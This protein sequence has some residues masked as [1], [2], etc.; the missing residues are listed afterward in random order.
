MIDLTDPAVATDLIT[1]ADASGAVDAAFDDDLSIFIDWTAGTDA[2]SGVASYTLKIFQQSSCGGSALSDITGLTGTSYN[3]TAPSEATYSFQLVTFDNAGN[4]SAASACS[5]DITIDQTN[6]VAATGLKTPVDVASG[7]DAD[8]DTTNTEIF[9]A[10][11]AATDAGSGLASYTLKRYDQASCGGTSSDT[12]GIGAGVSSQSFTGVEGTTYSFEVVAIDNAGNSAT[13]LCSSDVMIDLTSPVAA[14]GLKTPVDVASGADADYDTTNTEIFF[15]WTA[16]TDAESGLASYTLKRYDQASCGG[17]STDTA[18][19]GAG[20]T[21]QSFTGVEGTTYSFEVVAIDDAGNST[22]SACSSD[23]MIDLT[24]PAVATDLITPADAAGAVDA[25]FDDDLSIFIDWTAGTDAGSGVASYTLKIF[26]QSSCGGSALSDITGLTGIS[27]NYTAPSD[28]TYS[29]QL[30]TIDNAGR[31]SAASACST[32]ILIDSEN[33]TAATDLITPADAAGG[34]DAAFDDD[35]SFYISWTAGT[36]AGSGV[37]DYTLKI[38]QQSSCGGSALSDITGLTGTSYN[39]TAPSEATYSFQLVTFD[40]SGRQSPVSACS[41]DITIDQT[42]P[43]AA[44]GLKTPVDVA[45]GADADYDTTNTEIFFAW[46]AATDAGSGLASYTLKRYDQASCGGTSSDTAGIG[47]GV[48]SQSFTG[49]EG[50]TYSFEVVAIDNAGNSATSAC[51]SDVMIDLTSPVAASGLKTPVDVA[52]GADADYDTT[53]TEI[54][55]AWTAATDAGS[56]L[57]SYTLKRYD[58]ASCGGTSTDTAGIGAGVSSQSFTGVE[59]TTYSFEVVAIDDAGNSTTSACS[60]D[61]MIDLTDPAVATDLITP[62]DASGAVDAAFDD[63]LSIFIDWTAGTDAGSGVASYTL[64]IFQQSACGGSALSDIT[65]LT[66]TSYNYTAP[67]EATYSFQLVT[68]DNSGRQSPVSACSTDITIDQTNP[69]AAT[70]LKT[71]VDVA[72]GADAN[73]DTTNTEIFFAW[74]A[75]TDAGSGLASYTLKRYDQA[76]CGGTSSDTAGIGA[77]FSSQSF[78]GVEGTTYSFEVVAIDNAGNSATSLC[79]SNVMIDLTSPVAASGLKTPVDVASGADADYDTTNTEIFFAWTAATDAGSGLAS[80]TLKRYDQASCGGTSTDTAGIGAG[81]SSQSFTGVE[82]TTYSFEVVAI[83]DAG[84]STTSACSSDVMIDLTDPAVATDL[85]T[86]AD[87][88]GAVDAAFDDDLSIFVDWVAGT[89]AG[90]GV[91]SYTL[92]IFQQSSCG[93]SALSDITGLTGTSYNYTAPSD[94]T[95][96]FQLVTIDNAGRQSAA[97]ACSTDILIDSENPTAATDLITPADAS[98]AGDAAFDD[99]LSFY[100]SW[101]AGTDAGSGVASYTLKIFQQSACGGSALSDITG[102]TGTSYNYTAPSEATYSFQLVTFDNSGRQSPV[103]ACSTDITIDQTNPVAATGLKTPVDVASGA[104][105]D[106]DTT[107]TE[108]FFAWVAATDAGSGLASYT[109]KRYDQASCGGTSS[110]TAGIGAGV[111]SQSFTGVE[112]TTYSFEVVAIDNAGNSATSACSSDVM[113]D[114]TSPVAASGLKTPV[115]VA[116][117]ADADYDTTNTEIFFAWTAAT[118][119]GSGLA[120]YTLK[121]YDQASCGGTSTD[122]AGIGA[123]VSSQSFTGVDGTAYSFEVVAIDDAGN[124]TTSA[125]SSDVMIDLTDPAVATDLITPA[126]ASGAGDAAF[127]DDLSFYIDWTAGTDAGSGVASYTLKIFQQSSCGGSALSDI[128]GLTGTS[129]NYT[130]PSEATYSFQLVTFDNSGRQSSVSACSTDINIDL[131]SPTAV[132]GL[133]TPADN[134]TDGDSLFD[135][136]ITIYFAWDFTDDGTGSG[137]QSYTLKRY[138]ESNCGGASTD[139]TGISNIINSQSFDGVGGTTYSF[140]VTAIDG[141]GNSSTSACSTD[142]TIDLTSPMAAS[143]LKTPVDVASGADADYDNTNTEIFFAWTAATDAESG[144]ASY[145]LKR[146][147]QASCG[148]TS[149]D[150]AGIG[151]SV[152]DQSFTGVD[153]TT[154]SFEVVAIDN[155]GNSTTSACSSDVMIDLTDPA[156]ATDLITPADASG[157]ADAAFDDDLSIFVDWSAGTD[158]GS[159][160]ASYT[161]KIFQQSSC[162]GSALSDITGLTGTS[163]N[164][165][166]PSEATYSFRLVTFDNAGNQ[167]TASACSTDINIDLTSPTAVSGLKTPADNATDGDSLFDDDITI[168]FAWDFTDDG[169]GSGVQSYTLKRYDESNCGGASTDTTGISNIINSQSFDGVGGTTYSFEVTAIDGA[170]NSSTSACSTDITL[171]LISPTAA[172]NLIT[173]ADAAGAGDA[174]FDDDLSIFV[175][176]TAGTDAGSGVADYTLKI[177]QQSSCGGS[178]LSDITGLTGTSYNY[179][180]PSEATYSFRLVTFDNAGNQSAASA[181]STDITIDQTNPV[182]ASGLKTPVDVA[183]GADANYDTTNTEIFFAWTAATDAGSGLASYTLKRYDQASCGGPSTDT[184]GIGAGVTDQSF[185]GVEGTTYSFEVVAID[186]AG[187]SATSLCSSN[188]MIDLTDPT[189]ASGLITPADASGETDA[190]FDNDLSFYVNWTAGTDTGSG[191]SNYT[192]KIFQQSSC[193]GSALSDITGLTGTSYNY[194]APSAATYSFQLVTIDDAGN[195]SAASV[196]STDITVDTVNPTTA[197]GL[198]TPADASGAVDAALDDDLSIYI[199][200]VAGSDSDSGVASYTLK[201]FQQSSCGGSSLSD[202]TGLSGTTYNYTAPSDATY[203]FRLVTI[204]NAGNQS[205]ASDC[206]TDIILDTTN[207]TAASNLITPA[208]ASGAGDATY[209]NDLSIYIDWVAG[210]DAGSGVDNYTLK[211]FQQGSCGGSALSD[212]TGLTGTTYNYTAPADGTYSFKLVTIDNLGFQSAESECSTN[213]TI[214]TVPPTVTIGNPSVT[215]TNASTPVSFTLTYEVAPVGLIADDITIA[216][217]IVGCTPAITNATS[218]SP[219]V[220]ISGCSNNGGGTITIEVAAGRSSDAA[221]NQDLGAGPSTAVDVDSTG[222]DA[223]GDGV[224]A[225]V[226]FD[227]TKPNIGDPAN[228][229]AM[230]TTWYIDPSNLNLV[231]PLVNGFD[232]N[233]DVDWGDGSAV[234][235]VSSYNDANATHTYGSAGY[236]TVTLTGL[237]EAWNMASHPNR[238]DLIRVNEL[239]SVGWLSLADAFNGAS[240]LVTV[241]GGGLAYVTTMQRMLSGTLNLHSA[242]FTGSNTISVTNLSSMFQNSLIHKLDLSTM[243]VSSVVDMSSMFSGATSLQ[244]VDVSTWDTSGGPT[245]TNFVAGANLNLKF[246]CTDPDTNVQGSLGGG[247]IN[248]EACGSA[249]IDADADGILIGTDFDDT[250]AHIGTVTPFSSTWETTGPSEAIEIPLQPGHDFNFLVDW[251]DGGASKVTSWNDPD[252]THTYASAGVYTVTVTGLMEAWEAIFVN[253]I[254]MKPE[255]NRLLTVDELGAVG[256]LDLERAFYRLSNL[257]TVSGGDVS[258]VTTMNQIFFADY[259]SNESSL[260][261]LNTGGWDTTNVTDFFAAFYGVNLVTSLDV[262]NFVTTNATNMERMFQRM[263]GIS[264]LNLQNFDTGN[265]TTM[266]SMFNGMTTLSSLNVSTFDTSSV[267]S[268]RN[269]FDGTSALTSLN[270]GSWNVSKVYTMESMFRSS[271]ISSLDLST[272]DTSSLVLFSLAFWQSDA[273]TLNLSG[274]KTSNV[275]GMAETFADMP[276]AT[277][278]YLLGWSTMHDPVADLWIN[279]NSASIYCTDADN[280]GMGTDGGTILGVTCPSSGLPDDDSDGVPN[281]VDAFPLNAGETHDT[282]GDGIGNVADNDDDG[283]GVID[284]TD[285]DDLKPHIGDVSLDPFQA[286]ARIVSKNEADRTISLPLRRG[287]HYNFNVAWGDGNTSVITSWDDPDATHIYPRING[288]NAYPRNYTVEI[289]G[290]VEAFATA[291]NSLKDG[292]LSASNPQYN[293]FTEIINLGSLG[294]LNLRRAF[295]DNP[296]LTAI[297]GGDVSHVTDM[298]DMFLCL[299]PLGGATNCSTSAITSIDISTWD[300]SKVTSAHAMFAGLTGLTTFDATA[301]E[302]NSMVDMERMFQEVQSLSSLNVSSW[303][304]S[305]VTSMRSAF[306]SMFSISTLDLS[307]WDSSRVTSSRSMLNGMTSLTNLNVA[308]FDTNRIEDI[309]YMFNG[310]PATTIDVSGFDVSRVTDF[311]AMFQ[312]TT[313]VTSLDLS[314]WVT[315]RAESLAFLF[316]GSNSL[317]TLDLRNFVTRSI[318]TFEAMFA[319]MSSATDLYLYNWDTSTPPTRTFTNWNFGISATVHCNDADN[320]GTGVSGTGTIFGGTNCSP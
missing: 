257:T 318:I 178:A 267:T 239:G 52:S 82:G 163:Y 258:N 300:T 188:V 37:A 1:P 245:N 84:N 28:G 230:V 174:A 234:S 80:Y 91:A 261:T 217:N 211:I 20:V 181:C 196:C 222:T 243:N 229:V 205:A 65:G 3:Y 317:L 279:N 273:V 41:T 223:D 204:D 173:P 46:V 105:A 144:L 122:T 309:G 12:A 142:I 248:G 19:I 175:D 165:T 77:G 281:V 72:S 184:A 139:T 6:P 283:D 131:T 103:S 207:P 136:D 66:G 5:T 307:A 264:S 233:F 117:G 4:Q 171:D 98:G 111:S 253:G 78:T 168:Y 36:D 166:A 138:D 22:T 109:L 156:V 23:V 216:G 93:G 202:I 85:I 266:R 68:F 290:L 225:G 47:A 314:N 274:W 227:D 17:T 278:I 57:A 92:K 313:G 212:I 294:Y 40:N 95:Y 145:T 160:V 169:T 232:Y 190:L 154:Y 316:S 60:S 242:D 58:Q 310:V 133:K 304:V 81:V 8:Y 220:T 298:A 305:K 303:D 55:F 151:V 250:R 89:D 291:L 215:T 219:T 185:T 236:Y 268:M 99:D 51:S 115:D 29:F 54:F 79:S 106:Y 113:I 18:G 231:L 246:V 88:A 249:N 9:F 235:S 240:N 295:Y 128:T 315:S 94:G 118:D 186:N 210:T 226:D 130:A 63:D 237:V 123:A 48:S 43:V 7:A 252:K 119:A 11:V 301:L 73:Y 263:E 285:Y 24:D 269:M 311:E 214:D 254:G 76:S 299:G 74:V 134:A 126:D 262:S 56:G 27:Y 247:T 241:T 42:N 224:I 14:S 284:T 203:S 302:T 162:G 288:G 125:C 147:D 286:T 53:N 25:A 187:N 135:D 198:I 61:V 200:W 34:P 26:Q 2:G 124:S 164:Y 101:T 320:G 86:P 189:V 107:N 150:T 50:T 70:G 158:A 120:S 116:S 297:S 192:L 195:Q 153:G 296:N 159:G 265:V 44:T 152:T 10:W 251:G 75:A 110:D 206:S 193:G 172:S 140:E 289:E 143:G 275:Q 180:A 39:Y 155:V 201:I 104:D 191:V 199:D 194:A 129:Y 177:F 161:L 259:T 100:I 49:V 282:D 132:S 64:K 293:R 30:V 218:T 96:S 312:D 176:W 13:S 197:S 16:A 244:T 33:P 306:N 260:T 179:T 277:D 67:S 45:S 146:Y 319:N 38:F 108:I 83:D 69:V 270:I 255:H 121:R 280:G 35:L 271:G 287:Y 102:L 272:W 21:D 97:S 276:N 149:T 183:S 209:D 32:D 59:G 167:S 62:A 256:W 182:A 221:G 228:I 137:V 208:D 71:P 15:A 292:D 31:Q 87:A 148:G 170:G 308:G 213:I 114:L 127:D 112:G 238:D 141:A 157:A 90:S